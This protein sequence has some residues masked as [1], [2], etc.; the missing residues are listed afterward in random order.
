MKRESSND[1]L[2]VGYPSDV[3]PFCSCNSYRSKARAYNSADDAKHNKKFNDGKS[4]CSIS[5]HVFIV[6][7]FFKK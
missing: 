3:A 1:L 7:R 2:G 5:M 4:L 6:G